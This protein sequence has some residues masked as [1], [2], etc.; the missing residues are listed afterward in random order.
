MNTATLWWNCLSRY[1]RAALL[2][3]KCCCWWSLLTR[4]RT[5]N[6]WRT[7][8]SYSS[9]RLVSLYFVIWHRYLSLLKL[10]FIAIIVFP[11]F[12]LTLLLN[13]LLELIITRE[14]NNSFHNVV[15]IF[16]RTSLSRICLLP[17]ALPGETTKNNCDQILFNICD[18][19][20]V[21]E[22]N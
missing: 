20:A 7:Y 8:I 17:C 21:R 11:I 16:I 4:T 22:N 1:V 19:S 18:E 12:H 9:L 13:S 5:R 14:K 3:F 6:G 10:W 2:V 15:E